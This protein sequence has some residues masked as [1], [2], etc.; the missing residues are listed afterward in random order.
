MTG[1]GSFA[2][3]LSIVK[4][5]AKGL[6]LLPSSQAN[7]TQLIILVAGRWF[8]IRTAIRVRVYGTNARSV[9]IPIVVLHNTYIRWCS[10]RVQIRID[11]RGVTVGRGA[12][13]TSK[14]NYRKQ[15]HND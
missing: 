12:I 1:N 15:T 8:A 5:K 2:S 14:T 11:V 9:L 13:A 10:V 4:G 7:S 6:C 3:H